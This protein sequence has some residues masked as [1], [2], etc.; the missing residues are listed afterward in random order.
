[1]QDI[2]KKLCVV[3]IGPGAIDKMTIEAHRALRESTVIVGYKTYIDCVREHFPD[4]EY[5]ASGMMKETERCREALRR[6][7]DHAIVSIISSGDPGL[8]GMASLIYELSGEYPEVE[9][10]VIS[11]VTAALS[12]AAILGS[13]LTN[14]TAIISLSDRLTPWEKIEKR[15]I[16][17]AE[18][19]FSI[20]IY[21]PASKGRPDHI[22]RAAD[23]LLTKLPGDRICGLA[24]QTGRE[25]QS[26][27]VCTLRE[28]RDMPVDMLTTVF[29]GCSDT[30]LKDGKMVT[31]R[32]Y[33]I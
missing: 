10:T 29:I 18:G 4:K 25:G 9:I 21:N 27:T 22:R 14:D 20:V 7:N 19:D 15:L 17:A 5:V 6:A 33:N 16:C 23:I 28:L 8:Y 11:G 1:M 3:G 30:A 24:R 32:G 26:V 2:P 13:P 31:R 12:G